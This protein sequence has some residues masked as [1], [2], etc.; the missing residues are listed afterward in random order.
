VDVIAFD[1]LLLLN[2]YNLIEIN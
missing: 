2:D 1:Q